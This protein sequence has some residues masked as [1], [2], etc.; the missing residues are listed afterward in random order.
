MDELTIL[1]YFKQEQYRTYQASKRRPLVHDI[2]LLAPV[3]IEPESDL[4]P[5]NIDL[6][7]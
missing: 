4:E 6:P 3:A 2:E 1:N 7:F 5:E